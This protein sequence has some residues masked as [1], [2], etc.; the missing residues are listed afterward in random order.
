[1]AKKKIG[2]VFAM[3]REDSK[4]IWQ[5]VDAEFGVGEPAMLV[6][7]YSDTVEIT[8]GKGSILINYETLP[9]LCSLLK[10]AYKS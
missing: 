4:V 3:T 9:D 6:N 2:P 5:Q 7:F 8:Q 1:M 10:Q